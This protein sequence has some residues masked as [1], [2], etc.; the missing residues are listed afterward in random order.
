MKRLMIVALLLS[1][2]VVLGQASAPAPKATTEPSMTG[3]PCCQM[4]MN[5]MNGMPMQNGAPMKM[6]MGMMMM[7]NGGMMMMGGGAAPS[8]SQPATQPSGQSGHQGM[9]GM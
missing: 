7:G 5:M 2:G 4:M 8:G 6:P 9:P 3:C 1:A